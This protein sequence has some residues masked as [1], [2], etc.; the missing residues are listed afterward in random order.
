MI[1]ESTAMFPLWMVISA[2]FGFLA[3][4][5]LGDLSRHRKDLLAANQELRERLEQAT[6]IKE[7]LDLKLA[8]ILAV[9]KGLEK[10]SS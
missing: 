4:V 3:G 5:T 7:P 10:P 8:R 1:D 2:S 6:A 9:A